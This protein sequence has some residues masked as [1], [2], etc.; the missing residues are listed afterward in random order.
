M[1]WSQCECRCSV[2]VAMNAVSRNLP[3]L[4]RETLNHPLEITDSL[5][6]QNYLR[7]SYMYVMSCGHF[8]TPFPPPAWHLP[9]QV[10][11]YIHGFLTCVN[12]LVQ[13]GNLSVLH[14]RRKWCTFLQQ[15]ANCSYSLGNGGVLWD[16]P[17]SVMMC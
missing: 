12:P 13:Y 6:L 17:P 7:G 1:V 5:Q 9:S 10:L 16:P 4:L 3:I 2:S 14:H 11:S 8:H 15:R